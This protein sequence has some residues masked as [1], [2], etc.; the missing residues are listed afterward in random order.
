MKGGSMNA[1]DDLEDA[2]GPVSGI[3]SIAGLREPAPPSG[4]LELS[5]G[6]V[7]SVVDGALELRDRGGRLLVRYSD[8]NAEIAA[9][10]GDLVLSSPTGRVVVRSALDVEVDAGRDVVQRAGRKLE[11]SAEGIALTAQKYELAATRIFEKSRDTFRSV[12][13]LCDT[14]VGRARTLVASLFTLKA[15]RTV[16]ASK[17]ETSIDGRKILLG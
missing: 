11:L 8:G 2:D 5:D 7:A 16:M 17:E 14:R 1:I 9:P 4:S 15:Q 13:D 6:A 3:T 10:S 12:A